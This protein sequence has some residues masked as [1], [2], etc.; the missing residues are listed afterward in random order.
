MPWQV[1]ST[2]KCFD[3]VHVYVASLQV[4]GDEQAK[5]VFHIFFVFLFCV[6]VFCVL[7][8]CFFV[9]LLLFF[10]FLLFVFCFSLT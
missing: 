9:S 1:V 3:V 7:F 2:L 10:V 8:Y 4:V 5:K 6:F